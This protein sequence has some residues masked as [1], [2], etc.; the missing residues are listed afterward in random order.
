MTDDDRERN[1]RDELEQLLI[2]LRLKKIREILDRESSRATKKQ[3][4]YTEFLARLLRE[5]YHYQ[6][7][8]AMEYRIRRAKLPER[9]AL[10][11]RD[12]P[13]QET[14]RGSAQN[15]PTVGRVGL[16][17]PGRKHRIDRTDRCRQNRLGLGHLAQSA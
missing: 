11:T 2:N 8:N 7:Q 4:S 14:T 5:Q 10:E 3:S 1:R 15:H 6:Q 13:V 12:L 16:R 17:T 9:W